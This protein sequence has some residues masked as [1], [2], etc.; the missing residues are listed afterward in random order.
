MNIVVFSCINFELTS[1][2]EKTL[3]KQGSTHKKA[4]YKLLVHFFIQFSFLFP[5]EYKLALKKSTR[6]ILLIKTGQRIKKINELDVDISFL[7]PRKF[8]TNI[9]SQ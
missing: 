2:K 9:A 8:K 5:C 6:S 7:K 1:I 4:F 3:N